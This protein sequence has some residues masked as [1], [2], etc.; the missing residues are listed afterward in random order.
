MSLCNQ[1]GGL[2]CIVINLFLK[3]SSEVWK[4]YLY[5]T[6]VL[7]LKSDESLNKK[8]K[9]TESDKIIIDAGSNNKTENGKLESPLKPGEQCRLFSNNLT[10]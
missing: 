10:E 1:N 7:R 3:C 8:P 9:V 6:V 2:F 4:V 5:T